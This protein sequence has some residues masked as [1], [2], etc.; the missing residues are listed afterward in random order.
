MEFVYL[1]ARVLTCGVWVAASGYKIAHYRHTL[2]EMQ[3]HRIPFAAPLLPVV[4][5]L[6]LAGALLL[7]LNIGVWAVCLAWLAFLVPASWIYHG[8]F[9]I[10]NGTI[11]FLHWILFWKNV[12][13][14]G[15]LL[16]LALLD[17][18]RPEW[19]VT[20]G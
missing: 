8:R 18:G 3:S 5:L 17:P 4:I 20:I 13:I 6:E 12:S 9:L 19:L 1:L 11:N 16:A 10:E 14:A 7:I 2:L 15:G